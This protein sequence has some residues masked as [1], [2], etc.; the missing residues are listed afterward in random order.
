[1]K[2]APPLRGLNS[3]PLISSTLVRFDNYLRTSHSHWDWFKPLALHV[4]PSFVIILG[5]IWYSCVLEVTFFVSTVLL[6]LNCE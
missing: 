4:S 5:L 3:T 6:C 2:R 1:M